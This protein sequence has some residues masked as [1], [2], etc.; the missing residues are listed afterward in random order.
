VTP[1]VTYGYDVRGWSYDA[2]FNEGRQFAIVSL[3]AEYQ[4][5]YTA[6]IAYQPIWGGRYNN[7]RDRDVLTMAVSARF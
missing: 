2:A 3:R 7:A 6:E 1:S 5:V 4:K